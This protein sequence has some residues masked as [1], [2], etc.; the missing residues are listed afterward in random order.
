M[1]V[2]AEPSARMSRLMPEAARLRPSLEAV[3]DALS[4]DE[5]NVM[6]RLFPD[7][8][9]GTRAIVGVGGQ[10]EKVDV[11]VLER[12]LREHR[13]RVVRAG[14]SGLE[15]VHEGGEDVELDAEEEAGLEV[16]LLLARPAIEFWNGHFFPPPPPWEPLEDERE[17]IEMSADAVG[18]IQVQGHR[19]RRWAGTGFVVGE[20]VVMTNAHVADVF[21]TSGQGGHWSFRRGMSSSINWADDPGADA[22]TEVPVTEVIGVHDRFDLALLR[23]AR[24]DDLPQPL[25]VA[26]DPPGSFAGRSVYVLGYPAFDPRNGG[27]AQRLIFGDKYDVKRLQPGE[28]LRRSAE[29]GRFDHDCSTLGG[30]SGSCV[31]DLETHLVIGLHFQGKYLRHNQAVALWE[32]ADDPLLVDAGV[33]TG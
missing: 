12:S 18:R 1:M 24:S 32:L 21:A 5:A 6:D 33:L 29:P 20:D 11:S 14:L 26:A 30:N 4:A 7:G 15:K 19:S 2:P 16:F 31:V 27:E 8:S 3:R 13:E 23:I 25:L 17:N 22:S 9:V 10:L 28:V